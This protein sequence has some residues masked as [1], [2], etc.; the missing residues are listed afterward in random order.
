[1]IIHNPF[2]QPEHFI[3]PKF[4]YYKHLADFFARYPFHEFV[5]EYESNVSGYCLS[6]NNGTYLLFVPKFNYQVSI[7]PGKSIYSIK[8]TYQW[9]N[10]QTGEYSSELQYDG[11]LFQNPW[12]EKA[13]AILIRKH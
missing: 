5:P 11:A 4:E 1:V 2:E 6:N 13:D 10:V 3:K 12:H 8:G 9:F 7:Y